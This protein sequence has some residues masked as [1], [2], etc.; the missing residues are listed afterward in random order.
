MKSFFPFKRTKA[1]QEEYL[2]WS[3]RP[4]ILAHIEGHLDETGKLTQVGDTLPDEDR[5]NK[6]AKI[7]WASGAMDGVLGHHMAGRNT[8]KLAAK[9]AA[10]VKSIA[11]KNGLP[12][13]VELYNLLLKENT[14]GLVDAALEKIGELN[15]PISPYLHDYAK[16]LAFQS[17]DAGAVKF[18]IALLG[19]I[20]DRRDLPQILTLGK[21]EEFTLFSAV[22]L[23]NVS[24]NPER[25]LWNLA[26]CV[27]GWGRIHIVE[28]LSETKDPEIKKWLVREG[29]KNAIMYEYLAYTCAVA[30]DLKGEL[31]AATVDQDLLSAAGEIIRA[32]IDGGPAESM[33]HYNDGAAVT[34]L[35]VAHILHAP[36]PDLGNF[37]I[38]HA[39][40]K[41]LESPDTNWD[42]RKTKGWT[43]NLK[44]NLLIDI[45]KML[46]AP[47]W[48][49]MV[50]EN[51]NSGDSLKSWQANE[52]GRVLGINTWESQWARL[53]E[54]PDSMECWFQI[55]KMVDA[56][57][58]DQVL[59]FATSVFPPEKMATGPENALGFGPG[60]ELHQC[61]G[62][63]LQDLDQYPNKG[64]ELI[65][66][67]LK[68]P[69][70]RNRILA[71]GALS[72]WNKD[73][74]PAG[75]KELLEEAEKEEPDDD[76][77]KELR[78]LLES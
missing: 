73:H 9:V 25:D 28:R 6:D 36:N 51:V 77:L 78:S 68:S 23:T 42:E 53:V 57:K 71:L 16:W 37:L 62:F 31:S 52:V 44:A 69:S 3:G 35:Y 19:R 11:Q 75:A 60:F 48:L 66:T 20:R 26:K 10:L 61:L 67:G 24:E 46:S 14:L 4:A 41:F 18:G 34:E 40:Q 33:D 21:H 30:G 55:M 43:D 29:F 72:T 58:L 63:V 45:Q 1:G 5:R 50:K 17:P 56:D 27:F 47:K 15:V 49:Q 12:E 64:F 38:L 59:D 32:L 8:G 76:I 70:K 2:P 54:K 74:W 65:K 13:K 7:K 39:I 22:A